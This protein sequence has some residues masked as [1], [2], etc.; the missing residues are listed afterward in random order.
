[1]LTCPI[2]VEC[3]LVVRL[4]S[5]AI[6]R[7]LGVCLFCLPSPSFRKRPSLIRRDGTGSK[8]CEACLG[9]ATRR[10]RTSFGGA[11]TCWVE[12]GKRVR[13]LWSTMAGGLLGI[14]STV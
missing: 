11:S 6:Q 5:I 1:M 9:R 10:G 12:L 8:P 2:R 7:F 14:P 13:S 4:P 3:P